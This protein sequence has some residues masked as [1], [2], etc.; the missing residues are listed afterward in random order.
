MVLLYIFYLFVEVF[1]ESAL[2]SCLMSIFM[3]ITLNYKAYCLSPFLLYL[4]SSIYLVLFLEF[5]LIH[6]FIAYSSVSSFCWTV[7]V[8][9]SEL[10]GTATSK[11]A[12]MVLYMGHLCVDCVWLVPS[13]GWLELCL[14]GLGSQCTPCCGYPGGMAG[15]EVSVGLGG[16]GVCVEGAPAGQLKLK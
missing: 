5:H 6:S 7:C 14:H 8:C 12:G 1:P 2:L 10:D 9:F 13:A 16:P 3:I 4:V 15:A 11:L